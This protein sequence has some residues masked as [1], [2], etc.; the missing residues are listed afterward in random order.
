MHDS[1]QPKVMVEPTAI[2]TP[3]PLPFQ[4]HSLTILPVRAALHRLIHRTYR[5]MR[6]L[7]HALLVAWLSAA[8]VEANSDPCP[9][10][11]PTICLLVLFLPRLFL[12]LLTRYPL[13]FSYWDINCND[14]A[15]FK[16]LDPQ[17][18]A[19]GAYTER[20]GPYGSK[21]AKIPNVDTL[22]GECR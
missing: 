18:C 7:I 3:I 17:F 16:Y 21:S 8:N 10:N 15:G 2:P 11:P 5:I 19:S 13:S 20:G 12:Q 9:S 14:F 1:L 22:Y 6:L 4:L